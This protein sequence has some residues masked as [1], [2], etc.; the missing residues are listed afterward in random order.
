ML[1]LNT[2]TPAAAFIALANILNRPLPLSFHSDDAGA[3]SSA[4]KLMLQT[5]AAKSKNLHDHLTKLPDH[6]ADL[7]MG[8]IFTSLFTTQLALDEASRLWDV[9]IFEGDA[10]LIRAGVAILL[11]HEMALL[12]AKNAGE[13]QKIIHSKKQRLVGKSGDEDRWMTMVREAGKNNS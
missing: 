4:Y 6:D 13:V 10:V 8:D 11:D 9:Y 12:S 2:S 3:K 7:Y 1:L 5:L